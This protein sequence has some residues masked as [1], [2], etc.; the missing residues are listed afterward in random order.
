MRSNVTLPTHAVKK[1]L[2][3][4]CEQLFD[5]VADIER[6]P[7][8]LSGWVEARIIERTGN[9]LRVRQRLG[10]PL[11]PQSF[12]STAEL[13]RPSR[14]SI[15]STDGPFRN[16]HINWQF[17][18]V[19]VERCEVELEVSLALKSRILDRLADA[20]HDTAARDILAR[21]ESRAHALYGAQKNT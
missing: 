5:L 7:D 11:L 6:Y 4:T 10:L 20:F 18:P 8:F 14:L 19:E 13:E 1:N 9:H 16:L 12:I 17:Q 15:H 2:P 21:F 3:Y